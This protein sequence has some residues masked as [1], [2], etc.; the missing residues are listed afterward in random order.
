[1]D[2]NQPATKGDITHLDRRVGRLENRFDG[3]ELRFDGLEQRF[4]KLERRFDEVKE[5]MKRHFEVVVEQLRHDLIGARHDEVEV[6]KDKSHEHERRITRL[7][8]FNGLTA[9]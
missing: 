1:M 6:L 2:E 8:R 4:D 7:E 3:L 5:E 9:A